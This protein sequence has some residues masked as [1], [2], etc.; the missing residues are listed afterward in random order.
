[1]ETAA[2][3]TV[4][5]LRNIKTMSILNNVVLWGKNTA[6]SIGDYVSASTLTMEGE[7]REI[8]IALETIYR[9]HKNRND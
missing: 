2:L 6:D 7:K 8:I 3:F 1:M 4:G 9:Y 5:Q